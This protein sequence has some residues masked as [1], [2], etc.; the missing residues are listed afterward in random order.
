[1]FSPKIA[2][3]NE[4][5]EVWNTEE[6]FDFPRG[7]A[8][9]R[10]CGYD[11]VEIA[12]FTIDADAFRIDAAR[13]RTVRRQAEQAGLE[14]CGLHWLLAKTEGYYLTSPDAVVRRKTAEYFSELARLCADLG[15]R[16]MVLG[17]PKQ[18]NLLPGV[19]KERA[20][21]YAEEVLAQ[22][23]PVLEQCDVKIAL[24]PLHPN[25]TDFLERSDEAVKLLEKIGAPQRI[26]LLLDCKAMAA[27]ERSIPELIHRCKDY[28]IHFHLNDPNLQGPGF[29][30]LDFVPVMQALKE[31]DYRGWLAVEP[32]DPAPGIKNLTTESLNYMKN[33]VAEVN[34]A[35]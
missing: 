28:L 27:E 18:R 5:F 11:G 1:M 15:G 23:V 2:F 9:L 17:S 26:A 8:F 34:A 12:P 30:D 19:L 4:M 16:C 14:I 10:R 13:R 7:F 25:E 32:F 29:G 6:G 20:F 31:I 24:E 33:C 3:C 35:H 22:V 21:D